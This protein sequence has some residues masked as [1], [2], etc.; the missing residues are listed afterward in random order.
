MSDPFAIADASIF[1]MAQCVDGTV[2]QGTTTYARRVLLSRDVE[3]ADLTSNV[4]MRVDTV[5]FPCVG[6]LR[7]KVSTVTIGGTA[8]VLEQRLA[9]DG[10][11][12]TWRVKA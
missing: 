10:Y 4:S 8:Y 1:G 7:P 12:E 2:T 9:D 3:Y 11:A 6:G 5:Q